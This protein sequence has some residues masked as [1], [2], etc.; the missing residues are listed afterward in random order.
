MSQAKKH[1]GGCHC[2][3]VRYSAEIDLSTPAVACNC[4]MCGRAGTL[5]SFVPVEKFQL[6]KGEA[7]LADYQF[8]KHVIHH[9]FCKTCGIKPFARGKSPK[10]GG[11]VVAINVRTLDDVDANAIPTKTFDGKSL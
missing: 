5:L 9:M 10:G 2:G 6:E 3:A 4:S 1:H 7:N 11:D 8:N